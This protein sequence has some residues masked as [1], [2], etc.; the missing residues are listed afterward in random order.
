MAEA[1]SSM[2]PTNPSND[3]LTIADRC[4]LA[5]DKVSQSSLV[6]ECPTIMV[7]LGRRLGISSSFWVPEK[8]KFYVDSPFQVWRFIGGSTDNNGCHLEGLQASAHGFCTFVLL[9]LTSLFNNASHRY[10]TFR[11]ECPH[12]AVSS[13]TC[14]CSSTGRFAPTREACFRSVCLLISERLFTTHC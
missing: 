6:L 12:G 3:W 8:M 9:D 14:E 1:M 5:L 2:A 10:L 7:Y 13:P 4:E 11:I